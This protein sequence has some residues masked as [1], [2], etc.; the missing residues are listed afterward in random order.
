MDRQEQIDKIAQW[1]GWSHSAFN[2][3]GYWRWNDANGKEAAKSK[4]D[5]FTSAKDCAVV[6][7]EVVKRG[8]WWWTIKSP[9]YEGQPFFAGFNPKATTGWNGRPDHQ[10]QSLDSW[11]EAFCNALPVGKE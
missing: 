7:E 5:P 11:M 1:M 10:G 6:M 8:E 9:F 4:F 2:N 3:F